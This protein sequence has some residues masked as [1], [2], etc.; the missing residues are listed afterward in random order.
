[1]STAFHPQTDGQTER[2]NQTIDAYLGSFVSKEQDD[3][4]HLLPMAEFAYKNSTTTGNGMSPFYLNY[5]FH[6]AAMDPSLNG[7]THPSQYGVCPLDER[8]AR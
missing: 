8:G 6:P 3:W 5:R 4:V 1:M 2:L 7:T